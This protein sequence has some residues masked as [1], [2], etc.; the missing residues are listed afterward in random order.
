[1]PL[2]WS[3]AGDSGETIADTIIYERVEFVRGATGLMTGAGEPSA[4][5][6]LVRKG[7]HST[8]FTGYVDA[9]TGRWSNNQLSADVATGLNSDGSIRGRLVAKAAE[10]D[11]YQDLYKDERYVAYGVVEGDLTDA[12]LLR[13]G[14]SYQKNDPTA[15]TWG[16]L[17]TWF[18]DGTRTDWSRST[19]TAARWT[20]WRTT[21]ENY[22]VNLSHS[23]ANDWRL[24]ANYNRLEYDQHTRL[25]YLY[26]NVDKATGEGLYS[27]PYRSSGDSKQDSFDLQLRGDYELFDRQHEFVI[28]ALYSNQ[29]SDTV[30]RDALEFP[31]VGNF[32][33]WNGRYPEPAWSDTENTEVNLKTEQE[34]Y[35]AV[36][37][38]GLTD[39]FNVIVGGRLANW[40]RKGYNYGETLDIDDNNEFIPYAGAL[41]DITDQHRVYLSYTEI[42][43]PQNVRDINGS[44]LEPAIGESAEFGLKSSFLDDNL[45]TTVS[46][47]QVKQDNLAQPTGEMIPGTIE[48]AYRA[49]DD[50]KTEGY[51]LEAV[52]ELAP[53]WQASFGYT[54]FK[55]EDSD[56][57]NVNTHHPRKLLKLFTSYQFGGMLNGLTLGA[58]VNWQGKI[59]SNIVNPATL[60]PARLEQDDYALVSLMARYRFNDNL[61]TQ[62]NVD[63][64]FDETYYS[65]VGFFDQYRY[66]TPL[67]YSWHI[68]YQ[69]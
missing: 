40:K 39:R 62:V 30:S 49:A 34:G 21:N 2:A 69:F 67:N 16:A 66:G 3:L 17:P 56:G 61:S 25:L 47:F 53:G 7:A 54:Y 28:G 5:I 26:G 33:D 29:N 46:I 51:E 41:Y 36:T 63:N 23:F 13:I 68:T 18:S 15:P 42:F 48:E 12:T 14:G 64:L 52:G 6:N 27:Y 50:T 1:M 8:D 59:Y 4:S 37:R 24:I 45:Q 19:T 60:A 38:L 58:G 10:G 22:F 20:R 32:Y 65:Q 31:P 44:F 55:A 9:G 43:E 57:V 35:Y 11:S